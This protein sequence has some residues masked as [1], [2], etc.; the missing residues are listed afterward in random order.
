VTQH[1]EPSFLEGFNAHKAATRTALLA[2]THALLVAAAFVLLMQAPQPSAS[3]AEFTEFYSSSDS[4]RLVI[5]ASLYL[6]PFA[7]IAF[8]WFIVALRM[9]I[10]RSAARKDELLSSGQL[11]SGILFLGLFFA[12]A[13]TMSVLALGADYSLSGI[14]ASTAQYF[15]RLGWALFVVFAMR[16]AAVFIMTTSA[17]GRRHGFIPTWFVAVGYAVSVALLLS[18]S[19]SSYLIL[20]MPGWLLILGVL[21][22]FR[23]RSLPEASRSP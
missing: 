15:A 5:I 8:L 2:I 20:V 6:L 4:R 1:D 12:G 18:A 11:V 9:W 23:S 17:L 13:A 14:E 19:T 3:N 16:M 22:L 7:G 21:L 10:G